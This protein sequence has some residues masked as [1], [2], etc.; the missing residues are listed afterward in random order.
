MSATGNPR[1][2]GFTLIEALVVMG[3]TALI[4]SLAFPAMR[5]AIGGQEFRAARSSVELTLRQ[6]RATAIRSGGAV[7]FRV[8][9][10]GAAISVDGSEAK[11][12]PDSLHLAPAQSVTFFPDGTSDG[13]TFRLSSK[14]RS[15][16]F[17]IF[18]TTGL[19]VVTP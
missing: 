7:G 15:A 4:S 11:P 10:G 19:I 14:N 13:G 17:T 1:A 16:S 9:G 2:N 3:V 5:S 12:L 6:T 18:P 8:T